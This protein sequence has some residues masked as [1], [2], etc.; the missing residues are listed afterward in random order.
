MQISFLQFIKE[1]QEIRDKLNRVCK[2]VKL[3][4]LKS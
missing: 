3:N 1:S 4:L 2:R